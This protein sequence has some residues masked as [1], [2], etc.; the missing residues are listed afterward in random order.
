MSSETPKDIGKDETVFRSIVERYLHD[1]HSRHPTLAQ[2]SGLHDWDGCLEDL[3]CEG[4]IEEARTVRG[5]VR[6]LADI[7]PEEL[8]RSDQLDLRFVLSNAQGRLQDIEEV[9]A[10]EKNPQTY[11]DTLATGMLNLALFDHCTESEKRRAITS[12]LRETPRLIES[13]QRNIKNPAPVFVKHGITSISGA[14]RLVEESLPRMF[15][16]GGSERSRCDLLSAVDGASR[17]LKGFLS[18]LKNDL[19][20]KAKGSFALGPAAYEAKLRYEEGVDIPSED[21]LKMGLERLQETD[22]DFRRTAARIDSRV[23]PTVIWQRIKQDHPAGGQL[24]PTA[25]AQLE[26]LIRFIEERKIVSLNGANAIKVGLTPE[27]LQWT[28]ASLWPLGAFEDRPFAARY[29]ITDVASHWS[30]AEKQQHLS[31]FAYPVLWVISIHEAYPGH[32]VQLSHL[33]NVKSRIRKVL[34][35]APGSFVEGWAH[36]SE[37]MMIDE[38]FGDG[39]PRI[40]LGQLSQSLI[41]LC[42]LIVSIKMHTQ[43]M[44]IEEATRFFMEQG[45]CEELPAQAEAERGAFDPGYLTYALGKMKIEK[46]REEFKRAAGDQFVLRDFHDRLLG[47]GMAPLWLHN[48]LMLANES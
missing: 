23:D 41:R 31:Y 21:L 10:W 18:Y 46:L 20:G 40:R 24:V 30:E 6:Q 1:F 48:E 37:Q 38:G 36:Y 39:D 22:E 35:L 44:T 17:S 3:S 26:E 43:D 32:A 2:C 19:A 7:N 12:K 11:G 15:N 9:R 45:R 28:F 34:G 14:L 33:K 8:T 4:L 29:L 16:N 25:E 47:I 42:R 13:A 5:F 27:F